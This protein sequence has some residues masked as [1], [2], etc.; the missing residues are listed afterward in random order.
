MLKDAGRIS[1][2]IAKVFAEEEFAKYR[3]I[4][5]QLHKSDFDK[6]IEASKNKINNEKKGSDT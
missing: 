5:D 2:E 1:A 6:L 3:I 4:Q